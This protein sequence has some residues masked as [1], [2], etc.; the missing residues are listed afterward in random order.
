MPQI[1]SAMSAEK[2]LHM[3]KVVDISQFNTKPS[4]R[5]GKTIP[6]LSEGFYDGFIE[7][8]ELFKD[9]NFI[10]DGFETK[11]KIVLLFPQLEAFQS[12]TDKLLRR[13]YY[14]ERPY[15]AQRSNFNKEVLS[16]FADPV[17]RL[18]FVDEEGSEVS[19]KVENL[20]ADKVNLSRLIL[21]SCR[22]GYDLMGAPVNAVLEVRNGRNKSYNLVTKIRGR[23][24][25]YLTEDAYA[26][27]TRDSQKAQ[28]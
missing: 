22:E 12:E 24:G 21:V 19:G 13:A 3:L 23:E 6:P 18:I 1:H 9:S 15:Y 17:E 11:I 16:H 5:Q 8:V 20:P 28:A 27:V 14:Y 7:K 4:P 10:G 26:Q 2:T 25:D